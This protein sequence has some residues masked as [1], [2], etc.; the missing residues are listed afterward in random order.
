LTEEAE[1]FGPHIPKGKRSVLSFDKNG[2]SHILGHIF[3]NSS[4]HPAAKHNRRSFCG[5]FNLRSA[6]ASIKCTNPR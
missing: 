6:I 1:N 3:K 4:G 2:L 5:N